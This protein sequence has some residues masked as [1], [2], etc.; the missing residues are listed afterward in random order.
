MNSLAASQTPWRQVKLLGNVLEDVLDGVLKGF[1]VHGG[2]EDVA[3]EGL[4]AIHDLVL[5]RT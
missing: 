3:G 4:G 1:L 5:S 2:S